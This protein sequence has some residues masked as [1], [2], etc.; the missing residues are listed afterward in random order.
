MGANIMGKSIIIIFCIFSILICDS[1]GYDIISFSPVIKDSKLN[2]FK[3]VKPSGQKSDC[4]WYG[5]SRLNNQWQELSFIFTSEG[6][7]LIVLRIRPWAKWREGDVPF[8]VDDIRVNGVPIKMD[9]KWR[10]S[11]PQ[12]VAELCSLRTTPGFA[13]SGKPYLRLYRSALGGMHD[14]MVKKGE[15]VEVTMKAKAGSVL[16][17]YNSRLL[18][19]T[20][21]VNEC[22]K[23]AKLCKGKQENKDQTLQLTKCINELIK[24][25]EEKMQIAIPLLAKS[26]NTPEQLKKKLTELIKAYKLKIKQDANLKEPILY[27]KLDARKEFLNKI[28]ELTHLVSL[29]KTDLI[30]NFIFQ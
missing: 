15:K 14:L 10:F 3:L 25:S 13:P 24:M 26:S 19:V 12:Q 2:K 28:R 29:L 20:E 11:P 30:L 8:Y 7:G 5:S 27:R 22:I 4:L 23:T 1:W 21:K 17:A 9:E 6:N 18:R 16:D